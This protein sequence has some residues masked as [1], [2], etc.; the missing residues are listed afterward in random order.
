[1]ASG[2]HYCPVAPFSEGHLGKVA[3]HHDQVALGHRQGKT[4]HHFSE[5]LILVLHT[6]LPNLLTCESCVTQ[7]KNLVI[8]WETMLIQVLA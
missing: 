5:Q 4:F 2:S 8:A 7:S 1:M 3:K 6:D